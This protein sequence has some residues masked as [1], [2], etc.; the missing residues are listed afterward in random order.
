MNSQKYNCL[1]PETVRRFE[2]MELLA[3]GIVEGFIAGLHKSPH[4]GF[5]VEFV[6]YR[7]YAPGDPVR[8]IDW[9]AYARNDR[10]V[11]R[12]Y[13]QETN[14][15]ASI[16]VDCSES[17]NFKSISILTKF[18]YAC[19]TAAALI[20]M[21]HRQQD[22]VGL[23]CH[24]GLIRKVF[25]PRTSAL[26][27]REMLLHLDGLKPGG[28]TQLPS[29]YHEMAERLPRR[30]LVILLTDL[31]D[32]PVKVANALRHFR[33]RRHEVLVFHLMDDAEL[34]FPFRGLIDFKDLETGQR[35]EVEAELI[36]DAVRKNVDAFISEYRKICGSAH[37]DY[38]VLNT[39]EPFGKALSA[40]LSKR[41]RV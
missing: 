17:L 38:H 36:R 22:A 37:I 4:H 18:Q 6:E 41:L 8:H 1:T 30:S 14:L 2:N 27:L 24:D 34:D 35:M 20:Y 13:E 7:E 26:A 40:C 33:H 10:F 23:V 32:D 11:I 12:Q 31:L 15:Q 3:R 25:P 29:V 5:S 19:H 21:L 9:A 39:S 16:F 28:Q